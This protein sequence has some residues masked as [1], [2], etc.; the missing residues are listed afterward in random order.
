MSDRAECGNP[1]ERGDGDAGREAKSVEFPPG[2]RNTR[3][4]RME[5]AV[6]T[7]L[8][9]DTLQGTG[10]CRA[11][12][13]SPSSATLL[14]LCALVKPPPRLSPD[15]IPPPLCTPQRIHTAPLVHSHRTAPI[16]LLPQPDLSLSPPSPICLPSKWL[17][18]PVRHSLFLP[19]PQAPLSHCASHT[20]AALHDDRS[21]FTLVRSNSRWLTL[22][23]SAARLPPDARPLDLVAPPLDLASTPADALPLG[24]A[25]SEAPAAD[26]LLLVLAPV[27]PHGEGAD[28]RPL[29][30]MPAIGLP[31]PDLG[32]GD[33]TLAMSACMLPAG[34][35]PAPISGD[36]GL[37]KS[38]RLASGDSPANA[39]CACMLLPDGAER[40]CCR[41]TPE[42]K[43]GS[44]APSLVAAGWGTSKGWALPL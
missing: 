40:W 29:A 2:E 44:G 25:C 6:D 32:S 14:P 30:L 33:A 13:E 39:C 27:P 31:A 11:K 42:G 4:G 41:L 7:L 18:S 1:G 19:T 21:A 38:M 3:H 20:C 5:L 24:L 16:V 28:A 34:G 43:E 8:A 26:A 10:Q 22:L 17:S 15:P 35:A 36:A 12:P 37:A 9:M 23:P